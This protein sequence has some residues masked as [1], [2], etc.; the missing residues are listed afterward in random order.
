MEISKNGQHFA[1]FLKG[2]VAIYIYQM[3]LSKVKILAKIF[4]KVHISHE[5]LEISKSRRNFAGFLK[6]SVVTQTYRM[7]LSNFQIFSKIIVKSQLPYKQLK[8]SKCEK[9]FTNENS[10]EWGIVITSLEEAGKL[11]SGCIIDFIWL[12][13]YSILSSLQVLLI[14]DTFI[15]LH[16]IFWIFSFEYSSFCNFSDFLFLICPYFFSFFQF[17]GFST[18]RFFDL[19]FLSIIAFHFFNFQIFSSI[20]SQIF[21]FYNFQNSHFSPFNFRFPIFPHYLSIHIPIHTTIN[22]YIYL[23][24]SFS[25]HLSTI[26]LILCPP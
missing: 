15:S 2:S 11:R 6:E 10:Y 20:F 12:F 17:S 7:V 25:I 14:F 22:Q 19:S 18:L 5:Q 16:F 23:F 8:I 4:A 13:F 24:L 3:V 26:N 9:V 1:S 21:D